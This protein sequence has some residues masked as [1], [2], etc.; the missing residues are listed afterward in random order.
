MT[1]L[2]GVTYQQIHAKYKESPLP[3]MLGTNI[4]V[5]IYDYWCSYC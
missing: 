3:S 5:I 1:K 2:T 4:A